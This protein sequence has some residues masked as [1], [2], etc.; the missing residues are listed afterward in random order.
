M[1]IKLI[2]AGIIFASCAYLGLRKSGDLKARGNALD[3][4]YAALLQLETEISFCVNDLKRAFLSIDKNTRTCGLFRDAAE[5]MEEYGIKKAWAYAVVKNPAPLNNDDRELIL[6]L[7]SKLGMTDAKNQLRHIAY[8]KEL[9][10]AQA[11]AAKSDYDR[12][13]KIYRSGGLL[14]GLFI[15]LIII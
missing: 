1:L 9:V 10:S 14:A 12:L 8:I 15:I 4:V 7:A 2:G 5:H 6:M 13:G 11:A 3:A